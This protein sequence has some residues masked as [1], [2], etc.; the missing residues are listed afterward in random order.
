[1]RLSFPRVTGRC[2]PGRKQN[3]PY[4]VT[5]CQ[6]Q[7]SNNSSDHYLP[8]CM[9]KQRKLK[10]SAISSRL[11]SGGLRPSVFPASSTPGIAEMLE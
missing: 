5:S 9:A 10:S 6:E 2:R 11:L 4:Q 7:T 8:I 1:M 3:G